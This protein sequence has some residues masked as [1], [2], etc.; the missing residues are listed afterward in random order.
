[1]PGMKGDAELADIARL[2]ATRDNRALQH[3]RPP[4]RGWPWVIV[5][6]GLSVVKSDGYRV[7]LHNRVGVIVAFGVVLAFSVLRPKP[8]RIA[9]AAAALVA[10]ALN[11]HAL[12]LGVAIAFGAFVLLMTLFTAVAAVLHAR[13]N[14]WP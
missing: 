6:V 2:A 3:N 9:V 12:A 8:V 13:Q 14:P 4:R 11:P 1:M 5:A 10:L 7:V